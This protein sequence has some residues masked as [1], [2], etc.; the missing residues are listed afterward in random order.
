[1][2]WSYPVRL[3][4]S[5]RLR[6]LE[7]RQDVQAELEKCALDL[8]IYYEEN[9]DLRRELNRCRLLIERREWP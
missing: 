2:I 9:L 4:R 8:A 7:A 6:E 1:L 3:I 5:K